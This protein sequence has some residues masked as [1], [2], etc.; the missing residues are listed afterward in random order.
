MKTESHLPRY[1]VIKQFVLEQINCGS[2][3]TNHR[4]PS[5]NELS[6]QFDVSRMTARRAL[7]ELTDAGVL[8]RTQG[9]GTFV[10]GPKAQSPLLEIKNI[11]EEIEARGNHYSN[12]VIEIG[13]VAASE[14]TSSALGLPSGVTVQFSIIV[15]SENGIPLQLEYRFVNPHHVPDYKNQDFA[16]QTPNQYLSKIAPLSEGEHQVEAI[17]PSPGDSKLLRIEIN[18]PCL[19]IK[20]R[21]W[22]SDKMISYAILIHPSSRY[23]LGGRISYQN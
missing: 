5:E 13:T 16:R 20:R 15:H 3:S 6:S 21:T 23:R 9:L 2:W 7:Q 19:Q 22:S 14:D 12:R 17:L 1:E 18:E 4:T 10:A 8:F 11:A